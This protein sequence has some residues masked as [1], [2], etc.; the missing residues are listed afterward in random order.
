MGEAGSV[1]F[2]LDRHFVCSSSEM[3]KD[4]VTEE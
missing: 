3:W 4:T 2:R 1:M